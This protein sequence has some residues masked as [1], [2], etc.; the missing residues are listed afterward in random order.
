VRF[1]MTPAWNGIML[2]VLLAEGSVPALATSTVN[3]RAL[4]HRSPG[5]CY[6]VNSP[7]REVDVHVVRLRGGAGEGIRV[8]DPML[9]KWNALSGWMHE[10]WEEIPAQQKHVLTGF[11]VKMVH[12]HAGISATSPLA[13]AESPAIKI[14]MMLLGIKVATRLLPQWEDLWTRLERVLRKFH[15]GSDYAAVSDV[16]RET[17]EAFWS[18]AIDAKVRVASLE[19]P[20]PGMLQVKGLSIGN[21]KGFSSEEAIHIESVSINLIFGAEHTRKVFASGTPLL[22]V[23]SMEI[24]GL[25]L[26]LEF[27]PLPQ[28]M[29]AEA[30][31]NIES[32]Q[33]KLN[34][35]SIPPPS[36]TTKVKR[37][38][39]IAVRLFSCDRA[40][41]SVAMGKGSHTF[42]M[43]AMTLTDIG[44][45]SEGGVYPQDMPGAVFSAIMN[46]IWAKLA[47]AQGEASSKVETALAPALAHAAAQAKTVEN[48]ARGFIG[49][50]T[51]FFQQGTH[52]QGE[53][54]SNSESFLKKKNSTCTS[55]T[56]ELDPPS[57]ST[58][59]PIPPVSENMTMKEGL[60]LMDEILVRFA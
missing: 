26:R 21:P 36:L 53:V 12:D 24:K 16:V 22:V 11:A 52:L 1:V 17:I 44:Q 31:T 38:A 30:K 60:D 45:E 42:E 57:P 51:S 48:L 7:V 27:L 20:S 50:V 58:Q 14:A 59:A 47:A 13:A 10:Q 37:A 34:K 4:A 28:L 35:L 56:S 5:G 41:V 25:S 9:A 19:C 8:E 18:Q 39:K 32:I 54:V 40:G 2:A 43:P 29:K 46:M 49:H 15:E 55:W 6:F 33:Q 23:K 3:M